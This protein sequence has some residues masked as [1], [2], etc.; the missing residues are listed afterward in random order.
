[1]EDWQTEEL[2]WTAAQEEFMLCR[3]ALR[4]V[5]TVGAQVDSLR[6]TGKS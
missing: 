5:V 3:V 1:M 2:H 4:A 6:G